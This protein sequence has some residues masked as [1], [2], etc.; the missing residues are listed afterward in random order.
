MNA[1]DGLSELN[2]SILQRDPLEGSVVVN[3]NVNEESTG[4]SNSI[5]G[6]NDVISARQPNNSIVYM[7][8]DSV[9]SVGDEVLED[10]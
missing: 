7:N 9:V 4:L 10:D 1:L 3:Q 8:R 6:R 5:I 2:G